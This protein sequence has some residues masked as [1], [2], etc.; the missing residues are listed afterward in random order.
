MVFLKGH[1]FAAGDG[2]PQWLA[3]GP[4]AASME[5]WRNLAESLTHTFS[6]GQWNP[7][8]INPLADIVQQSVDFERLRQ[9]REIGL[10]ISATSAQAWAMGIFRNAEMSAE[11]VTASA[12]LP[13]MYNCG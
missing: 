5:L 13:Q 3:S 4:W 2:V 11:V 6:P 8:N 7:F 12:C 9:T 1:F 10:F